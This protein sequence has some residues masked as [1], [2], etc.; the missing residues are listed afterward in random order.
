M[1]STQ[2]I[3]VSELKQLL[4]SFQQPISRTFQKARQLTFIN[5]ACQFSTT[6]LPPDLKD[7]TERPSNLLLRITNKNC[8]GGP[9]LE[10]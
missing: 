2:S 5:F 7:A 4:E 10:I 6:D 8:L 1:Y 9:A 3:Q